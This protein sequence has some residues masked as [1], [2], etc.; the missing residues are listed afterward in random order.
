MLLWWK[1]AEIT[2]LNSDKFNCNFFLF[3]IYLFFF[4]RLMK[5]RLFQVSLLELSANHD[6]LTKRAR[7]ICA[8]GFTSRH[9]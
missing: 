8:A 2:E 4:C 5:K 1:R 7:T 3:F 9:R 6:D